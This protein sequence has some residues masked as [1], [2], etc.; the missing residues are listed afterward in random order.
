MVAL[1]C[2]AQM[3]LQI[4]NVWLDLLCADV[5]VSRYYRL[6]ER[7]AENVPQLIFQIVARFYVPFLL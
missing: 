2:Y 7:N 1:I 4:V 6:A 5:Y 3:H